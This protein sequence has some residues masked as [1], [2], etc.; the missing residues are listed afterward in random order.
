MKK[1]L[2]VALCAVILM[3]GIKLSDI[4]NRPS[5]DVTQYEI[6]SYKI[7]PNDTLWDLSTQFCKDSDNR[8]AWI[9]TVMEVNH[10]SDTIHSGNYIIIY[11]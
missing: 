6:T 5:I 11:K 3:S 7:Q 1:I 2:T 9:N 10:C 8:Q 4:F